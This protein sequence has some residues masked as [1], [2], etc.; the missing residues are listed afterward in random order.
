MLEKRL[1]Q[2]AK[3]IAI[4]GVHVQKNQNVVI[5]AGVDNASFVRKLVKACY[6]AQAKK[7]TVEWNDAFINRMDYEYQSIEELCDV[8]D[9]TIEKMR[10]Q[11]ESGSCFIS[12][13]SPISEIMKGI[14]SKKISSRNIAYSKQTKPFQ[15][16]TSAN[17]TQWCVVA[18]SNKVWA[19]KVFSDLDEEEANEKLWD[20]ILS[21]CHVFEDND[22]V[23]AW[24]EHD[25]AFAH[26]IAL[27]NELNF[28]ELHFVNGKGTDLHVALAPNHIWAGG[29]EKTQKDEIIFNPN[30]P[31]EEIFTM[32]YRNYVNGRVY[33]TKPLDYSGTLIEDFYLDFK[34]GRVV[35]YH[36]EKGMEA[37]KELIEFDE[38]SHYIGEVA[39]VPFHSPISQM[40]LLFYN[41]LFDENA[42]CH[43]ALGAAYPTTVKNGENM[44]GE[45]LLE[46]GANDSLL[47]VDF[48]FGSEDMHV[49][50]VGFDGKE[51]DIFVQGDFVI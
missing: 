44:T 1:D 13:T 43:L 29:Y 18:A 47:H 21:S 24:K 6:E 40:N 39:L 46:A 37:L 27:L 48:M 51:T 33:S 12:I 15:K 34:D 25:E 3:L 45:Q 31:T 22:P 32:P 5:R 41:T 17:L 28:K 11:Y 50:G 16:Y 8:K 26:R 19:K 30:M 4:S 35:N 7:V 10:D 23:L 20:A 14:D 49:I 42:S 2:Y 9:Y 36:A 38:G